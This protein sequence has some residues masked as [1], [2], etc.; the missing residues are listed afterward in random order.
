M[1]SLSIFLNVNILT[2]LQSYCY[3]EY[4]IRIPEILISKGKDYFLRCLLFL[5][6]KLSYFYSFLGLLIIGPNVWS[7]LKHYAVS[8]KP[9]KPLGGSFY[10]HKI[11]EPAAI[12]A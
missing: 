4:Y 6:R 2:K 11:S 10:S 1:H 7:H 9:P 5:P 3:Y 8:F 12:P